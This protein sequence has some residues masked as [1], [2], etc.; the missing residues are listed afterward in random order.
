MSSL[1]MGRPQPLLTLANNAETSK[2]CDSCGEDA[3]IYGMKPSSLL[4]NIS[5]WL[6]CLHHSTLWLSKLI[7]SCSTN[8][9]HRRDD[10]NNFA[11]LSS[12]CRSHSLQIRV[13]I[14]S[15]V[16]LYLIKGADTAVSSRTW[17][18]VAS[19]QVVSGSLSTM[20]ARLRLAL[21]R[22][23][24]PTITGNK[25]CSI[26]TTLLCYVDPP[27]FFL[28]KSWFLTFPCKRTTWARQENLRPS[29]PLSRPRHCL[30]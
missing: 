20:F 18:I 27:W 26:H 25:Q 10:G 19:F 17:F 28:V 11:T 13:G 7:P 4:S 2:S 16:F 30:E 24:L 14:W 23:S 15:V 3:R 21:T 12:H 5:K 29:I 9:C 6:S 22:A 8:D 1:L